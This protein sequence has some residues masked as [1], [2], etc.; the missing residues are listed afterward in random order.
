MIND[1]VDV[2]NARILNIKIDFVI[3]ADLEYNRY[4]TLAS[5]MTTLQQKIKTS[6]IGG[7]FY[8]S[9]IYKILNDV[10]GVL[11]V[12]SV[13]VSQKTGANYADLDY[14]I[15]DY[16]SP[17]GRYFTVPDDVIVEVKYPLQDIKGAIK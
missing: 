13:K 4:N 15:Y 7:A 10:N 16:M 9:D 17:D 6:D 11:D 3:I 5:A 1:T 14:D 2:M 12:Q 8:I